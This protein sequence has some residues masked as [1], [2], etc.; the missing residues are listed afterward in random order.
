MLR[1][2]EEGQ[3]LVETAFSVS[4]MVAMILGAVEFG[5]VAFA[6]IEINNAAKAAAQYGSQNHS[7]ALDQ[8]GMLQAAQN[9]FATPTAVSLSSPSGTSGYSCVCADTGAT[10]SCTNN[11]LT[12]PACPGSYVEMTLTVQ[13]QSTFHPLF[14]VPGLPTSYN[15]V[16]TAQQ[17]VL[18]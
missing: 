12:S 5:R 14:S 11:S 16:G 13:A 15:L 7:T 18:Q 3:A 8:S 9:E 17:D 10:A 6:A 2:R 4:L 1:N